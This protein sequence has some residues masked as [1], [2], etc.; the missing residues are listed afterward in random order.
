SL[1]RLNHWLPRG[2]THPEVMQS[3]AE[4]HDQIADPFV[5]QANPVFDEAAALG[6]A[7]DMVEPQ[8]TLV[9]RLVRHVL[10]PLKRLPQ[11]GINTSLTP[12]VSTFATLPFHG[13][14]LVAMGMSD[15]GPIDTVS[16]T[17][18]R[19]GRERSSTT[20]ESYVGIAGVQSTRDS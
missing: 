20:G 11:I 1:S 12:C 19:E 17:G 4:F 3:T 8:P 7:V 13:C 18:G 10:L 14:C 9:E 2:Q 5:P 6:T 15:L 16:R